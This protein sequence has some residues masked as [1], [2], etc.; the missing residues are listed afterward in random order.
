MKPLKVELK[1]FQ[2]FKFSTSSVYEI[3]EVAPYILKFSP[4]KSLKKAPVLGLL[5]LT[6]GNEH[7]GLPILNTIAE[8]LI[9]GTLNVDCE[10]YLGLGNIPAALE[11]KRYLEEDLNRC[12]ALTSRETLESRRARELE[13]HMLNHCDYLIDIHQT[14]HVSEAPF[15]IFQY[16]NEECLTQVNRWNPVTPWNKGIPVVLQENQ[17]GTDT[18]LSTDEYIRKKGKFGVALELGQLGSDSYQDLG[19]K[20]CLNA[21]N[22]VNEPTSS[23]PKEFSFPIMWLNG[24]YC[25]DDSS[26]ELDSGWYNLKSFKKG[27]RLGTN[28]K[29]EILAPANGC[30]IFPRYKKLSQG[31]ELF[32]YCT[33]FDP[34]FKPKTLVTEQEILVSP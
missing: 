2:N 28:G 34:N 29:G 14:A 24:I 22:T 12:F 8:S 27:Q 20:I 1:H 21:L 10:V 5:G 15:F 19:L 18:G 30:I 31:E 23:T 32:F 13:V 33:P 7:I 11:N 4:K 25:A 16:T 17:I 9:N 6:H 3:Q 26:C